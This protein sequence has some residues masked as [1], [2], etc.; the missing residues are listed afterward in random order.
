MGD[1]DREMRHGNC[2]RIATCFAS[3]Q[4]A[5]SWVASPTRHVRAGTSSHFGIPTIGYGK[6]NGEE[7]TR[8]TVNGYPA[9]AFSAVMVEREVDP[10]RQGKC[11][12]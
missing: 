9:A 1:H 6:S 12:V 3:L 11:G 7:N 2:H 8:V 5:K 10:C 4:A